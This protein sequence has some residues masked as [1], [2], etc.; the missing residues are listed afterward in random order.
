VTVIAAGFEGGQPP[1]RQ[2]GISRSADLRSGGNGGG[3]PQQAPQ[4]PAQTQAP[5][6]SYESVRPVPAAT[7]SGATA[8]PA[9]TPRPAQLRPP[10]PP[11]DDDLDVPDFL[12]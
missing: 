2:P 3:R 4:A 1:R 10:S 8:G 9:T 7:P 6:P 11:A 12:K 5:G